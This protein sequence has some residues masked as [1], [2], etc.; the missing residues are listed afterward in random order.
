MKYPPVLGAGLWMLGTL[1]SFSVMAIAAREL[2]ADFSTLQ[3]L[4][5][6]SAIGLLVVC[7]L[8]TRVGWGQVATAE[9]GIHLVRNLAH[10]LGQFGWFYAIASIP[11]AAVFAIEFTVPLWTVMFA[12]ILL[13]ERITP[14]RIIALLFGISGVLVILRP[15]MEVVHVAALVMLGGAFAYGLSHTLTKRLAPN[16][17]PLCIL[18]YMMIIQLP[19]GLVPSVFGWVT[20]Q[21]AHWPWFVLVGLTGLSA[22]YCMVR[23]LALAD[24]SIVIPMDLLRLPLIAIL[25]FALY[26]ERVDKYLA[27]GAVMILAG[28]GLNLL[29][30]RKKLMDKR[31][32]QQQA[33]SAEP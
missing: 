21:A 8:L 29:W 26:G 30:E 7:A 5:I 31:N 33:L 19:L 18:F 4:A 16:N 28:N 15:G 13:G 32:L 27:L 23:A 11:L 17:T 1:L 9:P 6:R 14:V 2:S 24:A 3:I 22:H 20:P 25:G 10:F 12:A